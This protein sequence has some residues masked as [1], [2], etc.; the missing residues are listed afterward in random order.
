MPSS[1][2]ARLTNT[3]RVKQI[4]GPATRPDAEFPP[5]NLP[6][7]PPYPPMEARSVDRIP[8]EG[9]YL[10]EPKWDGFRCLAFRKGLRDH[11][12]FTSS[13]NR[14]Q[15]EAIKDVVEPLR[16]K[17]GSTVEHQAIGRMAIA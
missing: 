12:G 13:F 8:D 4:A 14:E 11:V 6:V 17:P 10:F 1:R 2:K 9:D 15:R 7:K 5:I 3:S 16:G